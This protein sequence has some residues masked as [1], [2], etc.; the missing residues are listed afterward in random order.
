MAKVS[1]LTGISQDELSTMRFDAAYTYLEQ[2]ME[3]DAYG[4]EHLPKTPQ[5][6]A[7]WCTEWNRIDQIFM[8]KI[9]K[10]LHIGICVI[11]DPRN[12][13][14]W[15]MYSK[16]DLAKYYRIYHAISHDNI[17]I[18]SS[19]MHASAHTMIKE[20]AKSRSLTFKSF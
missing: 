19:V 17:H 4:M 7:W 3:V 6:W 2:V 10:D 18:N 8:Y 15:A 11:E 20:L 1:M 12:G 13:Q 14:L 16:A 9:R 5:F